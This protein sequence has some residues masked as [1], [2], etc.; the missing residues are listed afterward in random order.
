M[1]LLGGS[2]HCEAART[3]DGNDAQPSSGR[4]WRRPSPALSVRGAP[5]PTS[6]LPAQRAPRGA[7][8]P[9]GPLWGPSSSHRL[10]RWYLTTRTSFVRCSRSAKK[11]SSSACTA[12]RTP[13]SKNTISCGKLRMRLRVKK[14]GSQRADS[15][16]ADEWIKAARP[17]SILTYSGRHILSFINNELRAE[18]LAQQQAFQQTMH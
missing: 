12:P 10:C 18:I 2:G 11:A 9:L 17:L 14:R 4:V 1:W 3:T 8:A 16:K 15:R 6:A 7:P 13:E 5:H